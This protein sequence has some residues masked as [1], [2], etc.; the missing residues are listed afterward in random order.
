M[1]LTT[2]PNCY[3][4]KVAGE[5][6][7]SFF[8]DTNGLQERS[9]ASH[10]RSS[11]TET[12]FKCRQL[13]IGSPL[14]KCNVTANIGIVFKSLP[15]CQTTEKH[16]LWEVG[17]WPA[18]LTGPYRTFHVLVRTLDTSGK[19]TLHYYCWSALW[20]LTEVGGL[21]GISLFEAFRSD[22]LKCRI[23]GLKWSCDHLQRGVNDSG[24]RFLMFAPVMDK[25]LQMWKGPLCGG[26]PI[27][28]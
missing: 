11:E 21:V 9:A 2:P 5:T 23:V 1:G 26:P 19:D 18:R 4:L 22:H 3:T 6:T 12:T 17:A 15:S 24:E 27:M 13:K 10:E 28:Y 20:S 7:F 16:Q 14:A 8:F 25:T